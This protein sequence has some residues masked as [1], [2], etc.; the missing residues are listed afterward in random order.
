MT[1][2]S[3]RFRRVFPSVLPAR[4]VSCCPNAETPCGNRFSASAVRAP[5]NWFPCSVSASQLG[6]RPTGRSTA[7]QGPHPSPARRL[8]RSAIRARRLPG[9]GLGCTAMSRIRSRQEPAPVMPGALRAQTASPSCSAF[10]LSLPAVC[11]WFLLLK[12]QTTFNRKEKTQHEQENQQS[13][14]AESG[15]DV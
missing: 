15:S 12:E 6:V 10:P 14:I 8:M 4:I 13:G 9:E 5:R 3:V 11:S 1:L 7:A 2:P